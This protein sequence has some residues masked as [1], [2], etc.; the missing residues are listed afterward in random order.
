MTTA[1]KITI[2][3]ILLIP[4]FVVLTLYYTKEGKEVYR[5]LAILCFAIAAVFDGVDGYVARRYNQRS[6]LGAILDPLA[7]KLLLVSGIVV[8]SF[9]HSPH[10]ESVPLWL[11]GTIIGR[12][13]LILIGMLVIQLVV[14]KV[15]VQ[16]RII[17][18]I[19]TVLQ[20]AVVLLILLKK[21]EDW[22][23]ALT[24]GAVFCTGISGLLYV[25][26]GTR[27][28]SAHPSSSPKPKVQSPESEEGAPS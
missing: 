19:A 3:R 2:L 23:P 14:G 4:V 26:D 28:L 12:D 20:M 24:L 15:K 6:E 11:T 21:K 17:G 7:D 27:Q 25:W 16:P 22:L 13:I 18:K 1:N 10:L 9:D 5:V 8:L